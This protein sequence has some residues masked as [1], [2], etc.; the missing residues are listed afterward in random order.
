MSKTIKKLEQGGCEPYCIKESDL[1]RLDARIENNE[2]TGIEIKDTLQRLMESHEKDK[3]L[4]NEQFTHLSAEIAKLNATMTQSA[5]S[6]KEVLTK[7]NELVGQLQ[8]ILLNNKAMENK[9]DNID[10]ELSAQ[11]ALEEEH[12]K[13][14]KEN[15]AAIFQRLGKLEQ[16]RNTVMSIGALIISLLTAAGLIAQIF[17]ALHK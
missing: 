4:F 13:K 14:A 12:H 3:Q 6:S 11:K 2:N 7:Q 15:F 16:H 8:Q 1:G 9:Q 10:K 5:E 17:Q